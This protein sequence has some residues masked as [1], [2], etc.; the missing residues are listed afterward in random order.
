MQ[1]KLKE[2]IVFRAFTVT[3]LYYHHIQ[4]SVSIWKIDGVAGVRKGHFL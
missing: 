3:V 1:Q 4:T 2:E